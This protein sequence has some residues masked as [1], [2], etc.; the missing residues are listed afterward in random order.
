MTSCYKQRHIA[1]VTTGLFLGWRFPSLYCPFACQLQYPLIY[2]CPTQRPEPHSGSFAGKCP[3]DFSWEDKWKRNLLSRVQLFATPWNSP[4]NSPGQ[5][6]GLGSCSLLQGIFP[7][8]GS[9]P[10]LPHC[11]Q[12]LYQ[13]KHQ[14]SPRTQSNYGEDKDTVKLWVPQ[15]PFLTSKMTVS[16]FLFWVLH[17][18]NKITFP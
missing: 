10:G 16:L 11:R 15:A 17:S 5:N 1:L 9:N 4:W 2:H 6:T 13:L 14:G 3:S 7:T 18:A 12:I 8:Q